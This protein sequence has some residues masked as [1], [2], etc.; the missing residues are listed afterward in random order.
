MNVNGISPKVSLPAIVGLVLGVVCLLAGAVLHDATLTTI[1]PTLIAGSGL[2]SVVGY[3]AD[4]GDVAAPVAH[5]KSDDL[6][7]AEVAARL[8]EGS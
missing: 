6:L 5:P 2:G 7:P 3:K 8:L 4:V 1:G